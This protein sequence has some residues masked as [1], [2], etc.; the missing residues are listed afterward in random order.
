[1]KTLRQILFIIDIAVTS[2]PPISSSTER[3]TEHGTSSSSSSSVWDGLFGDQWKEKDIENVWGQA[4]SKRPN[5]GLI[6]IIFIFD[7]RC[8]FNAV[9]ITDWNGIIQIE[10]IWPDGLHQGMG[11][12]DWKR[13]KEGKKR[14][15]KIIIFVIFL[16][17]VCKKSFLICRCMACV[18]C[19]HS[20]TVC[21]I[22]FFTLTNESI[23][24]TNHR[25]TLSKVK[26]GHFTDKFW[27]L[28]MQ[29]S[30]FIR[31]MSLFHL[32]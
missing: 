32:W 18:L 27:C 23:A 21:Q 29:T 2:T 14:K 16:C 4:W 1:M 17:F 13:E 10:W 5:Q 8:D 12:R 31:K 25:L 19:T 22:G 3:E 20:T 28:I 26:K 7:A 30:K 9:A 6:A 24:L 15:V 11:K